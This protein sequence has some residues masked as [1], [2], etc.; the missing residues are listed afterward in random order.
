MQTLRKKARA[1]GL[2][3]IDISGVPAA[4]AAGSILERARKKRLNISKSFFISHTDA[5]TRIG[6]EVNVQTIQIGTHPRGAKLG[7]HYYV[8]NLE[9]A[10]K[11]LRARKR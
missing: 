8:P 10:I 7:A 6:R 11:L 5:G 3:V 4:R 9:A 1:Y 2:R